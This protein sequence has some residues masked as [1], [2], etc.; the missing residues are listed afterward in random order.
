MNKMKMLWCRFQQCL[1]PSAILLVEESS[2]TGRFR[3]L[4]DNV[5]G[6]CNFQNTKTMQVIFF[7]KYLKFN[8][9]FR[10]APRNGK[11]VFC[12]WANCIWICIVKLSLLR[13]FPRAA[14]VLIS[15]LK[16]LHANK[17]DFYQ[18]NWRGSD[19]EYDKG[20]VMQILKVLLPVYSV[21]CW[22]VLW[23]GTF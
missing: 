16:I 10:K 15:S 19:D 21:A 8:L 2:E 6:V 9:D 12:F 7:P 17:R 4:S 20:A 1:G 23:N 3:H 14:N 18:L 13:C 22:T 5:F 11:K